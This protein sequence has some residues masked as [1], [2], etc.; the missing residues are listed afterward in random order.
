M[1]WGI[2][3]TFSGQIP[4]VVGWVLAGKEVAVYPTQGEAEKAM[5]RLRRDKRYTW[6]YT[7]LETAEYGGKR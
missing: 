1:S 2:R 7:R 3:M 6:R 4:P 5:N